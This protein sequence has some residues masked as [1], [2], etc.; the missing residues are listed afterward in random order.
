MYFD[1][2]G[3]AKLSGRDLPPKSTAGN[4]V[5]GIRSNGTANNAYSSKTNGSGAALKATRNG[6]KTG[7]VATPIKSNGAVLTKDDGGVLEDVLDTSS[8]RGEDNQIAGATEAAAV[9]PPLP[10]PPGASPDRTS[11]G[12]GTIDRL[13]EEEGDRDKSAMASSVRDGRKQ[14]SVG[15]TNAPSAGPTNAPSTG[16]SNPSRK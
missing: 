11:A 2:L 9:T 5:N 10:P 15:P 3:P 12:N 16:P 13:T 1:A 8:R 7:D 4:H 14:S 6:A